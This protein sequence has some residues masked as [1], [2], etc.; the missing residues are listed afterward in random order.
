MLAQR[1]GL[2][3]W[4]MP[5]TW[6]EDPDSSVHIVRTGAGRAGGLGGSADTKLI[7]YLEAHRDG[8]TWL[9]AVRGSDAAAAIILQAHGIPVMA[10]GGFSG[11][12]PAP[13]VAQL[14]QYVAEGTLHYVLTG[15]AGGFGG[16]G[17]GAA[18]TASSVTS[19]LEQNCTAV[20][21]SAYGGSAASASASAGASAGAGAV[22]AA[23]A[24]TLYRCG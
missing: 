12:D 5:I 24:Q 14:Q 8:A 15:G 22:A 3:I 21:A 18:D 2:L 10:M 19:W 20:P 7:A 11:T 17:G 13:T 4:E 23:A 9:V 1:R 16:F 6:V